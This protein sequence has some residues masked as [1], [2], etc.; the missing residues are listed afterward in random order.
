MVIA[1]SLND[2]RRGR[3]C[4]T[5]NGGDGSSRSPAHRRAGPTHAEPVRTL[6]NAEGRPA[7]G[8]T[9][10]VADVFVTP[11]PAAV[12]HDSP[13]GPNGLW[14]HVHR[15]TDWPAAP[16][17]TAPS[18]PLL[19]RF[20]PASGS[21]SWTTDCR[22]TTCGTSRPS[23]PRSARSTSRPRRR[24][25][26]VRPAV[27][28]GDG[29]GLQTVGRRRGVLAGQTRTPPPT[30]TCRGWSTPI[31]STKC[32]ATRRRCPAGSVPLALHYSV[33]PVTNG[34]RG[35]TGP[36][37]GWWSA[38]YRRSWPRAGCGSWRDRDT[39]AR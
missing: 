5:Q 29:A 22:T 10:A 25:R 24:G 38:S 17:R 8:F 9:P 32:G 36:T 27:V 39:R 14:L 20:G 15:D 33:V 28:C 11:H 2:P 12:L 16:N 3:A 31:G 35:T 1:S 23:G 4:R 18:S 30:T 34:S 7:S 26:G 19:S 13:A 6:S 21:A 37:G